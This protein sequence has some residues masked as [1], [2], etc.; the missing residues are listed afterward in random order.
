MS[1]CAIV[2]AVLFSPQNKSVG[3]GTKQCV[4]I[5]E[6]R[7]AGWPLDGLSEK[8]YTVTI[9]DILFSQTDRCALRQACGP[10]SAERVLNLNI[11][12]I[13]LLDGGDSL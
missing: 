4:E 12:H 2:I 9:Y 5:T 13:L 10:Q 6:Q 1:T 3:T 11:P 7:V 8:R